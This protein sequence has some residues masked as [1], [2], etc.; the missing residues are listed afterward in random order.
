MECLA[1]NLHS[2][3][4][5]ISE[6][7]NAYSTLLIVYT[8]DYTVLGGTHTFIDLPLVSIGKSREARAMIR[9]ETA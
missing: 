3:H 1:A 7:W 4:M 2:E 5:T 9:H 6:T 8:K